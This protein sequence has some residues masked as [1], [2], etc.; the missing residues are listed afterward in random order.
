V[1]RRHAPEMNSGSSYQLGAYQRIKVVDRL[2]RGIQCCW[3]VI[4]GKESSEEIKVNQS[5]RANK[6]G[7]TGKK[8]SYTSLP[9]RMAAVSHN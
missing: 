3:W 2:R 9:R 4:R 1:D 6:P 5:T 7:R 8:N